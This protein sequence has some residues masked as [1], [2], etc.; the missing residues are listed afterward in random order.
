VLTLPYRVCYLLAWPYDLRRAMAR[1]LHRAIERHLRCWAR[2]HGVH[3]ARGGG[4]AV[5]PVQ[6][7]LRFVATVN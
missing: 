7:R 6:R 4:I 5:F 2:G 3:D 1:I